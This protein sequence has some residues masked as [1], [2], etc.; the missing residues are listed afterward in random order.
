M[1]KALLSTITAGL[2]V[3]GCGGTSG[4]H[5]TSTPAASTPHTQTQAAQAAATTTT[6]T[7]KPK[8]VHKVAHHK[9]AAKPKAVAKTASTPPVTTHSSPPPVTT[10]SAPPPVTTSAA[11]VVA[12]PKPTG[13]STTQ[14]GNTK[15]N[16]GSQ[17]YSLSQ[18]GY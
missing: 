2:L 10:Q 8:P 6:T 13:S 1:R 4:S 12:A 14:S 16:K 15:K 5:S 3:A 17:G 9:A 7:A 11:P 18:Q